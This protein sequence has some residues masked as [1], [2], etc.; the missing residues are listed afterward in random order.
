VEMDE[1]QR[2]L[3]VGR[4]KVVRDRAE[5]RGCASSWP[6]PT[7]RGGGGLGARA[8]ATSTKDGEMIGNPASR[9]GSGGSSA[10]TALTEVRL[11]HLGL[12]RFG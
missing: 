8:E 1:G 7:R 6:T 4:P 2:D 3:W 11:R 9:G 12:A 5:R 10:L